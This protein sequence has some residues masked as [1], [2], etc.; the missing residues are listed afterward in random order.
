MLDT[1]LLV[2]LRLLVVGIP[3]APTLK[4]WWYWMIDLKNGDGVG[5]AEMAYAMLPKPKNARER[6][7][8]REKEKERGVACVVK[9]KCVEVRL[10]IWSRGLYYTFSPKRRPWHATASR[11]RII[12]EAG[13]TPHVNTITPLH[14]DGRAWCKGSGIWNRAPLA[15]KTAPSHGIVNAMRQLP[16]HVRA[17]N[18][19]SSSRGARGR[20]RR[21]WNNTSSSTAYQRCMSMFDQGQ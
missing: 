15:T 10:V 4:P 20:R 21:P 11:I 17:A 13:R 9:F 19:R 18:C 8:Q 7:R 16:G 3:I 6:D 1:L 14:P 5:D 2:D 12:A